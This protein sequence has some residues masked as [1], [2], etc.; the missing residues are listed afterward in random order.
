MAASTG[1][2]SIAE[3][4]EDGVEFDDSTND[5]LSDLGALSGELTF[6]LNTH[7]NTSSVLLLSMQ[8]WQC[9]AQAC[10]YQD[11]LRTDSNWELV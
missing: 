11:H 7:A 3:A 2:R 8:E 6:C 10:V 4:K 5:F 1:G 9:T